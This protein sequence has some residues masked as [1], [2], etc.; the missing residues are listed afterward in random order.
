MERI[1]M[2]CLSVVVAWCATVPLA[3]QHR[4]FKNYGCAEGLISS[5]IYHVLQDDDG[6]I[7]CCADNGVSRFDGTSFRNY[8]MEDGLTDYGAFR[9]FKDSR[10]RLWFVTFSGNICFYQHGR[11]TPFQHPGIPTHAAVTWIDE[12]AEG[13]LWLATKTGEVYGIDKRDSVRYRKVSTGK[14]VHAAAANGVL[15]VSTVDTTYAVQHQGTVQR[16]AVHTQK[17]FSILPRCFPVSNGRVF[18]TS[19]MGIHEVLR[20]GVVHRVLPFT[21]SFPMCDVRLLYND[22]D[23]DMWICT[24]KGIYLLRGGE[25]HPEHAERVLEND[26]IS[27]LFTDREGSYWISTLSQGIYYA[28]HKHVMHYTV[29]DGLDGSIVHRLAALQPH[30]MLMV[31]ERGSMSVLLHG[32]ITPVATEVRSARGVAYSNLYPLAQGAYWLVIGGL[33]WKIQGERVALQYDNVYVVG[34]AYGGVCCWVRRDSIFIQD[35]AGHSQF[36]VTMPGIEPF[37]ALVGVAIDSAHTCWLAT[38]NGLYTYGRGQQKAVLWD[39]AHTACSLYI[40]DV[41]VDAMNTVW[42]AT[43]GGGI[44]R[45]RGKDSYSITTHNGLTGNICSRFYIDEQRHLWVMT[46][47]GATK[48]VSTGWRQEQLTTY[49]T[50]NGLISNEVQHVCVRDSLVYIATKEGV[51]VFNTHQ[52]PSVLPPPLV[53][54][55]QV[56]VEGQEVSTMQQN[57]FGEHVNS[58]SFQFVGISYRSRGQISYRY[59]LLGH[60]NSDTAWVQ[61]MQNNI[62]FSA[63]TPG[64]YQFEVSACNAEGVWS[65]QPA[66]MAFTIRTPL[67]QQRWFQVVGALVALLL[68]WGGVHLR[69]KAVASRNKLQQRLITTE[70]QALRAQMNPH[71]IFNSLN[72]IQDFILDKQPKEANYYLARFARLMRMIIEYSRRTSIS[73]A[74]EVAF[75]TTYLQLEELRFEGR[76]SFDI[77]VEPSIPVGVGIPPILIQPIVENAIKHGL[78]P[79]RDS[80]VL[81]VR[82]AM[83]K[84]MLVCTVEDNGVGR[85]V[86]AQQKTAER[87]EARE[88]VGITNTSERIALLLNLWKNNTEGKLH[89]DMVD[90]YSA[91]GTATGTRVHIVIPQQ[92]AQVS[93]RR[94]TPAE[95][96]KQ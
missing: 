7:W 81:T 1:V 53:H 38:K 4:F 51:S 86:A 9:M 67:W 27:F 39:N 54:I 56:R 82:F 26:D 29:R 89:V 19:E 71:F 68:L 44:V 49:T 66:R 79:K 61:T 64:E 36:A 21:Q 40:S 14:I 78:A 47:Q 23:G 74:E 45:I 3:A 84:A 52:Q 72:S 16:I 35:S 48:I 59:R 37:P 70:L 60:G 58:V 87:E 8:G 94:V 25:L 96:K 75:L 88:S 12:D 46:P 83:E 80:G 85:A 11:F 24:S 62:Y 95:E 93:T 15:Y 18:L 92:P 10:G 65:M 20:N 77:V 22:S 32:R 76:F 43:M 41:Y 50:H 31:Q 6:Y 34:R 42:V 73:V 33:P 91:E 90:L 17:I 57:T 28:S 69:L 63:L 2:V 13:V 5:T 30:G 55:Q